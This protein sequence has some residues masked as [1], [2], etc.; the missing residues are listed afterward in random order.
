MLK[1]DNIYK[2][3]ILLSVDAKYLVYVLRQIIMHF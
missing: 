1:N 2:I 3:V